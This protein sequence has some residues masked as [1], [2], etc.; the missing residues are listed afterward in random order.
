MLQ[1]GT[2]IPVRSIGFRRLA[3]W[4]E[5]CKSCLSQGWVLTVTWS[6]GSFTW[7]GCKSPGSAWDP[8]LHSYES[9]GFNLITRVSVNRLGF[10]YTQKNGWYFNGSRKE[11][12][13]ACTICGLLAKSAHFLKQGKDVK[14]SLQEVPG[15][16]GA[17]LH[18]RTSLAICERSIRAKR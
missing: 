17:A 3:G 4:L 2:S 1:S 13:E 10:L 7:Q 14:R 8:W 9:L 12:N 11:D 18:H 16:L 5:S 6:P 15:L